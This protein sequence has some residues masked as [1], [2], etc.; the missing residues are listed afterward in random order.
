MVNTGAG[1]SQTR[2]REGLCMFLLFCVSRLCLLFY[3]VLFV[4]V[5]KCC[6]FSVQHGG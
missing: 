3:L 4:T 1:G 5:E 2:V 6:I